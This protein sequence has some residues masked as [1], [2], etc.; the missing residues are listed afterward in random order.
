M[1]QIRIGDVSLPETS[2]DKYACWEETLD[3]QRVMI[4]GRLTIETRGKVWKSSY[5]Y[6]Y[7]GNDLLRRA[8]A[9]LRSGAPFIATVLP[10]NS[11]QTVTSTFVVERMSQPTMAFSRRKGDSKAA[12]WHNLSFTLREENPHK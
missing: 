12:F 1:D 3:V 9:V 11:D 7:M 10:D 6:D 5:S 4:S 2:R 8:L